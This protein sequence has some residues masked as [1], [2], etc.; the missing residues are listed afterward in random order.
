MKFSVQWH[1]AGVN[2]VGLLSCLPTITVKRVDRHFLKE[3]VY[4]TYNNLT[5]LILL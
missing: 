3:T 2:R 5:A 4:E 1:A